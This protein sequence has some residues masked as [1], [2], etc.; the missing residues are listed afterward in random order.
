MA[1]PTEAEEKFLNY[2]ST[3]EMYNKEDKVPIVYEK[4]SERKKCDLCGTGKLHRHYVLVDKGIREYLLSLG[5]F[6]DIPLDDESQSPAKRL[7]E[8]S[9]V[10]HVSQGVKVNT[11]PTQEGKEKVVTNG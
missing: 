6:N 10:E 3:F 9:A 11:D 4:S 5:E 7:P 8:M 1:K 2:I